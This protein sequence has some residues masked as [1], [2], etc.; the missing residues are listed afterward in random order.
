MTYGQGV[1]LPW[2]HLYL[3]HNLQELVSKLNDNPD[4]QVKSDKSTMTLG[5]GTFLAITSSVVLKS[6]AAILCKHCG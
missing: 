3:Q 2:K 4:F 6:G 5:L 1:L